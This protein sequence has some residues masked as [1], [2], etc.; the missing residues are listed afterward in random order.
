MYKHGH[1]INKKTEGVSPEYSVWCGILRRCTNVNDKSYPRYGGAGIEVCQEWKDSFAAFL[2]HVGP[3]PSLQHS[4]DRYPNPSGNYEPGN[5]RWASLSEQRRNHKKPDLHLLTVNGVTKCIADWAKESGLSAFTISTRILQLG[6]SHE[7]AVSL[8][9]S[10][11][12]RREN[13]HK[14]YLITINGK[15]MHLREWI[16][17]SEV[18]YH[19]AYARIYRMGWEPERAIFTPAGGRQ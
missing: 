17:I 8:P 9:P 12:I 18:K 4:I 11:N 10:R 1:A 5:V 2:V 15:T 19:T 13:R 16:K 7:D 14:N 3:R 6:W